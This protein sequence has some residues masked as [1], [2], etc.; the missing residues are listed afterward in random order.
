ML[1][2]MRF[3]HARDRRRE[4]HRRRHEAV[5]D[6]VVLGERDDVEAALVGPGALL[7]TGGVQLRV[8]HVGEG[9]DPQVVAQTEHRHR[10]PSTT[11]TLP[12]PRRPVP[13]RCRRAASS[14]SASSDSSSG[15]QARRELLHGARADDR[16]RDH[17]VG[18]AARRARRRPAPR[19]ARGRSASHASSCRTMLLDRLRA[20]DRTRAGPPARLAEHTAE[21]AAAR[22]GSTG[23]RRGRSARQAGRTSSSIVRAVRLYRL[24]SETSPRKLARRRPRWRCAMCQPA[25]L[26]LPT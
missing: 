17:R 14:V 18:A 26:L 1:I 19:R 10:H 5:V 21:Q 24:C 16:R 4:R 6:A 12:A 22:A 9:R 13:A 20:A 23:S 8:R 7:E 15:A 11:R 2:W 25:K 3:V